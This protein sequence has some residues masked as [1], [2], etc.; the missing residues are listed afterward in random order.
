M[1]CVLVGVGIGPAYLEETGVLLGEHQCV[2]SD[3]ELLRTT[4]TVEER[5]CASCHVHRREQ[6]I[7]LKERWQVTEIPEYRIHDGVISRRN[8]FG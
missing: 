1:S 2:N 6:Q 4:H 7:F 3:S 5:G 8:V